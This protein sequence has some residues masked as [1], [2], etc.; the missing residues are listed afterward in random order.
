[1]KTE[2]QFFYRCKD[3]RFHKEHRYRG[4]AKLTPKPP[5][6]ASGIEI[7][8]EVRIVPDKEESAALHE[9][10][11][12]IYI[13]VPGRHTD[14]ES[15][16]SLLAIHLMEQIK[17]SAGD[18][19]FA[20]QGGMTLWQHIPESADD[21][22]EID[23]KPYGVTLR[24]QEVLSTPAFESKRFVD[25]ASCDA[26]L[27]AQH[28]AAREANSAIDKCLG[29]MKI[30]E[31]EACS[32]NR[33]LSLRDALIRNHKIFEIFRVLVEYGNETAERE[34]YARFVTAVVAARNQC[35]HLR[36]R[37]DFGLTPND[38][39]VERDVVPYLETLEVLTRQLVLSTSGPHG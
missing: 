25:G 24:I 37:A 35:A 17:F 15:H 16:I 14:T 4:T 27:V 30:L 33:T 36:S 6:K 3:F 31:N 22:V 2:W 23:G 11:G 9:Q 10:R 38:P 29:F 8:A 32:S 5:N 20:I 7:P 21:E 18:G 26:D 12:R 28:N 19:S 1:M 39:R 13:T 34:G